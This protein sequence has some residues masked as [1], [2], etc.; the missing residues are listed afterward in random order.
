M[1]TTIDL[2]ERLLNKLKRLASQNKTTLS[3]CVESL[4][5]EQMVQKKEVKEQSF[6]LL[7]VSGEL[8]D[9]SLDLNRSSELLVQDDLEQFKNNNS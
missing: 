6:E 4:L 8:L 2:N 7:T 5:M 1:R 3:K 9:Q